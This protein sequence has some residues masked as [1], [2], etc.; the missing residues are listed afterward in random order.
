MPTGTRNFRSEAVF[1][2]L[3]GIPEG[4]PRYGFGILE[5]EGRSLRVPGGVLQG[6]SA[7]ANEDEA[8]PS[9]FDAVLELRPRPACS[10][11][12]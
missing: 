9:S 4:F 7:R 12:G 3:G 2:R 1:T 11:A 8:D 10:R 6:R 5:P